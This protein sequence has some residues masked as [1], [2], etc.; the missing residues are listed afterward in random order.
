M[1]ALF[2]ADLWL[3]TL[4]F[5]RFT[6]FCEIMAQHFIILCF[7]KYSIFSSYGYDPLV[8]K[9][10]YYFVVSYVAKFMTYH[11]VCNCSNMTKHPSSPPVF[12]AVGVA[13][14]YVFCVVFCRSLLV[15]LSFFFRP[16]CC[17]FLD[18]W[19]LITPLISSNSS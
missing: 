2:H 6:T 15:L 16:L 9:T 13:G 7:P 11:R 3:C 18:L 5:S 10:Y 4:L 19:H 12:S 1:E 14:S 8:H 17:L